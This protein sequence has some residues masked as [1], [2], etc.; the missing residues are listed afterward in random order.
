MESELFLET[1]E[2]DLLTVE[3]AEADRGCRLDAAL[4]AQLEQ[5]SRS[6]AQA[7]IAAGDVTV[8][9]HPRTD[10]NYRVRAGDR[11]EVKLYQSVPVDIVPE[12]IPLDIVYED[13]S[14]LVV[15]K[16][17]GMVVHPAPGSETGTLVNAL[18]GHMADGMDALS[19]IN[20]KLRPGIVHRIDKHTSGLIVIAKNDAAHAALSAQLAAHS[21]T[22]V[23]EA[24][25]AGR[26]RKDE[27]TIDAPLMR[28]PKNR[29]RQKVAPEGS[30]RRAVTH[31]KVLERYAKYTLIELRL[32][33][34]RTH[35]IRAH[36]AFLG[37][38]V[39]G[40]DLYGPADGDGQYLHAKTLGFLHPVTGDYL[41]FSADP[42]E[43]F[44][45]MVEKLRRSRQG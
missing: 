16:P 30:G 36:L 13:E 28:D 42:P 7:L 37:H 17:K 21:V 38:P 32:E 23:Y 39:L 40:D 33:T 26:F 11:A 31:Y 2:Y 3:F 29:K 18:L 22:R 24:I 45:A 34:G 44:R 8:N 20:G 14:V 19:G 25:A 41:E 43:D 15:N 4:A 12:S 9:G 6:R 27:G 1:D 10:K 35:Q 5:V